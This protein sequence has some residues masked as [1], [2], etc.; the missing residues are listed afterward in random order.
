M[1]KLHK[2]SGKEPIYTRLKGRS[3][4]PIT[5]EIDVGDLNNTICTIC[6]KEYNSR[7]TYKAHMNRAHKDGKR[8]PATIG[9]KINVNV[10]PIWGDPNNYC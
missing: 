1:I 10:V 7:K 3:V 8:E 4:N 5:F 9:G 2:D 6:D